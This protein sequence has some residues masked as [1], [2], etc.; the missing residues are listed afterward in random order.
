MALEMAI[1][2]SSQQHRRLGI[3]DIND[4]TFGP[5]GPVTAEAVAAVER[6]RGGA[7]ALA[8]EVLYHLAVGLRKMF[9]SY[10]GGEAA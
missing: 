3:R 4:T 1:R 2:K 9:C 5:G 10:R 6:G 7:K 8:V